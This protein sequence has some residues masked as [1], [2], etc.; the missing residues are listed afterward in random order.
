[1][2]KKYILMML[3]LTSISSCKKLL[4]TTPTDF[5][6]PEAYYQNADQLQVGL[7]SVYDSMAGT[8]VYGSIYPYYFNTSTD[9]EHNKTV[10]TGS[11]VYQYDPSDA[12]IASLWRGIYAGIERDN[13]LLSSIDQPKMDETKRNVIKGEAL[14]LRGYFYFLLVTNFGDVPLLIT[15]TAS[16]VDVSVPRT[17]T[18]DV[19]AQILKD[20][21]AAETLLQTQTAASLG[22]SGK[23]T[24]TAA[25]G[26][27]ARVCLYMSGYPLN[28][29]SK[30]QGAYNWAKKVVDSKEH[31]LNPD[32]T[33]IFINYAQDKYEIKE[34]LWELEYWGNNTGGVNEGS[35]YT[36]QWAGILCMDQSKG[37]SNGLVNTTRKLFDSYGVD[38][39]ST[40]TPNKASLDLRRDWN[41]ANYTWGSTATATRANNTNPW[42]M[43]SGKWRREYELLTP[44]D[45]NYTPEN[46]PVIRYADVLLM[47]AEASN[48]INGPTQEAID[49]VNLV[50]RRGWGKFSKGEG[51]KT[52]NVIAGGAGYTTVPIVAITGGGG[53][54]VVA[55]AKTTSGKVTSVAITDQGGGFT[56]IPTITFTGGGGAGAT[57]SATLTLITDADLDAT[58]TASP[59]VFRQAI[60]DERGRELCFELLRRPD[61]IRWGNFVADMKDF[62]AYAKANGATTVAMTAPAD[63]VAPRNLLLPIP[64]HDLSVNKA[65]TQNPG[66]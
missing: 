64:T 48:E 55:V 52:I 50:R 34:N 30:Y 20:L 41:C 1:M 8:L 49:A 62:G 35:R 10:T 7:N 32:Y 44:G 58:Q 40:T 29:H 14:F 39:R 45:K 25:E 22:Y 11:I 18:K 47:L 31:S 9:L 43:C 27:L 23:I 12:N 60:K 24:K 46:F 36:G 37:Y 53:T 57:A 5:I 28:D 6:S 17:P 38:P 15:P 4:D 66:Y 26:M 51:I 61:L 19:Y 3:L 56:S 42:T 2:K 16:V 33:Q 54:G 65:L 21:T 59:D 63:N 13:L